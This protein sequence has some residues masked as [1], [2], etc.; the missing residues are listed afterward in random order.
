MTA[1]T[2]PSPRSNEPERQYQ[3]V[4]VAALTGRNIRTVR[5]WFREERIPGAKK[6]NGMWYISKT[7]LIQ[8]LKGDTE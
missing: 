1:S 3:P 4:E 6:I 2:D 5:A 7:D 8:F